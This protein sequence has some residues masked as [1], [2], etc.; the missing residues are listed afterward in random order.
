M[1]YAIVRL[2]FVVMCCML[3]SSLAGTGSNISFL[4]WSFEGNFVCLLSTEKP[5]TAFEN[6]F[7]NTF[8]FQQDRCF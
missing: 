4:L 7:S 6:A 5:Y 2:I 3:S 8:D 1:H